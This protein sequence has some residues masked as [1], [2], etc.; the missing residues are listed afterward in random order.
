MIPDLPRLF[1][2][3]DYDDLEPARDLLSDMNPEHCGVKIGSEMFTAFGPAWVRE[4]VHQGF[5]V[6]LDLKYHDIPNTVEHACLA[7]AG[8]GIKMLNVHASGGFTMMKQAQDALNRLKN[9]PLLI[10]VTLL[11]S[12]T[13][14]EVEKV[15]MQSNLHDCVL[16]LAQ[17]TQ[18]AGLG[19]VVCS[20]EEAATLRQA[21]GPDF[22]LITPGIRLE[23]DTKDDQKRVMTPQM[24][25]KAGSDYLVVGRPITRSPHPKQ[26]IQS[27]LAIIE[28]QR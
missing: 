24:A 22:K 28:Q 10:A 3:F 2:A 21:C 14:E 4:V 20:A 25:L 27:L 9:P 15:G 26:V 5:S 17:L 8:L 7:A 12:L 18:A 11:T 19:G 1:V 13:Q 6:F 16:R 23:E